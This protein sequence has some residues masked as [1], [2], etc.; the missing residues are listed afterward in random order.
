[1][2]IQHALRSAAAR[3]ARRTSLLVG[4]ALVFVTSAGEPLYRPFN[5][6]LLAIRI[7]W[8]VVMAAAGLA[9]PRVSS[10]ACGIIMPL[11]GLL[12]V[13]LFSATVWMNGG[14]ASP[15]YQ[16]LTLLPLALMVVYQDEVITNAVV[17]VSTLSAV[18]VLSWLG[19]A[20]LS[21]TADMLS[22][23]GLVGVLTVFGA[24]TFRRVRIAEITTQEA[25][26]EAQ[27][28]RTEALE[29]LAMSE[30]RR[31]QA[32]RLASL[33]QLAA[34]V[35]HEINNPLYCVS[36]NVEA[37]LGDH[38][39]GG[40]ALSAAETQAALADVQLGV[41]RIAQI[42]RDLKQFSS[43]GMDEV[44]PC[45]I[46]EVIGDALRLAA[47]KLGK[48]VEVRRSSAPHLPRVLV[49]RRK[50]SQVLL[51]LLV[52]AADAMEEARTA[53][54]WVMVAT[55]RVGDAIQIVVQDNGPGVPRDVAARLFEPFMTTKP[56]G[57][58]TGLGLA[59]SREYVASFGGQIELQPSAGTGARFAIALP[60]AP[61][62][63]EPPPRRSTEIR[64][65]SDIS[66]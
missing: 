66:N 21:A 32:E 25:R 43:G 29:Q 7:A 12:S 6:P 33:G 53:N 23:V 18:A 46:D 56:V 42:V 45:P 37:L 10:R 51:N 40:P 65:R 22:T 61:E 28:A 58:G 48:S 31:A 24:S 52:N 63:T 9:A 62:P 30:H 35:A 5:G 26:A 41:D 38:D 50:L 16:Y 34:G 39:Q 49:N 27:R 57:K 64:I 4:A 2:N 44:K 36:A 3:K 11:A 14:V 60:A 13:W 17:V 19:D 1:M 55:E 59:L 54:P 20:P 47:F 15:D 8:C